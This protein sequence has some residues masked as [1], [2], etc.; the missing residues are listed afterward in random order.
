MVAPVRMLLHLTDIT[1]VVTAELGPVLRP[2]MI[3]GLVVAPVVVVTAPPPVV[4]ALSAI[5]TA[6]PAIV[7]TAALCSPCTCEYCQSRAQDKRTHIVLRI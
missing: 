5:I 1:S 7:T 3:V 4:T 2:E 6:W